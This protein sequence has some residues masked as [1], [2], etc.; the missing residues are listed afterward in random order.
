[1]SDRKE[2][3]TLIAHVKDSVESLKKFLSSVDWDHAHNGYVKE[4]SEP[5]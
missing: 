1:V 5:S 4:N 2:G 3:E